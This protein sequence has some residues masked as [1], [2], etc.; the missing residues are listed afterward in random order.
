MISMGLAALQG[1]CE[2]GKRHF[3]KTIV[4]PENHL[5]QGIFLNGKQINVNI[6]LGLCSIQRT[7]F[8][9]AFS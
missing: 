5:P 3:H 4:K 2:N 6:H 9:P 1:E 8:R 7:H